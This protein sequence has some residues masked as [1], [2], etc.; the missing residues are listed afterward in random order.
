MRRSGSKKEERRKK[1]RRITRY[2]R[3]S[4]LRA[5][6]RYL[7][8]VG[9]PPLSQESYGLWPMVAYDAPCGGG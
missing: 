6:W 4:L 9:P 5:P 7:V 8:A 1:K 2:A 3:T